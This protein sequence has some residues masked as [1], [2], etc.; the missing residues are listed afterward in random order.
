MVKLYAQLDAFDGGWDRRED[1]ACQDKSRAIQSQAEEADINTIVK[2]FGV[3]G[4]LPLVD[5]PPLDA[6]FDAVV[7]YRGLMDL[8]IAADRSFLQMPAAVRRRFHDDPAEFVD[9]CSDR[10]N[11]PE[12]RKLGLAIP[13][14]VVQTPVA[15]PP[16]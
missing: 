6:D 9:F 7:D 15:G 2:R 13:E 12:M 8:K 5:R 11:L 10:E 1:L 3:T 4:Q 16:A 14:P